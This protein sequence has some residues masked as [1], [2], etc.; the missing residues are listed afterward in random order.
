[1][2]WEEVEEK[3]KAKQDSYFI[4]CD[5]PDEFVFVIKTVQEQFPQLDQ[6][7]IKT[8]IYACRNAVSFPRSRR[9]FLECL[10][11]RLA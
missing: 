3:I 4:S 6:D 1:M 9:I 10:K 2:G 5:T 11:Q 7:R 8:A